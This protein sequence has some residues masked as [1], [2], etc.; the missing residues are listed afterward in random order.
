MASMITS[1][2]MHLGGGGPPLVLLHGI[3]MSWKVWRPVIPALEEDHTVLA[4]TLAGHL[5]GPSLIAGAH[6]IGPVADA[7]ESMLD[8]QGID[9]AHLV[10]NSLGGWL[11]CE[12]AQ[13][14]RASSVVAFSPA[15]AWETQRDQ[16]R[17]VRLMRLTRRSA[18]WSSTRRL[19][20]RPGLRRA[21]MK[22]ALERGDLIPDE[23]ALEMLAET[24]ACLL[25]EG[26]LGWIDEFGSIPGFDIDPACPVRLAWPV[27]DRT[28]PF[29]SYGRAFHALIP[30]AELVP[31]RGVGHVP[32][33]DDPGLVSRTILDFTAHTRHTPE[34]SKC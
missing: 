30:H 16:R 29:D 19:L 26:L 4:P 8:A 25:L 22:L 11:A 6:G 23:V 13:R 18:Q 17:I 33:F 7:V 31:L 20:S 34:G 21:A 15:G 10:G 28:I 2:E 14:G 3:N 32:M 1:P 9:Q 24:R 12:L 5:G 27:A